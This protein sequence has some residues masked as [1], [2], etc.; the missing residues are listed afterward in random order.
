MKNKKLSEEEKEFERLIRAK[1]AN[2]LL[3]RSK[4]GVIAL[5]VGFRVKGGELTNEKVVK[6]YVAKKIEKKDLSDKDLIPSKLKINGKL[7]PTD[8]EEGEIDQIQIFNL[9]TRPLVGGC[10][11]SPHN[12]W[13]TGT[14]G[15]CITLNDDRTYILSNNHVLADSNQLA[16]GTNIIQPSRGDGGDPV[17]DVIASLHDFVRLRFG[18]FT[19]NLFGLTFTL[20]HTNIVDAAIAEVNDDFNG[21]NREIHWAGYPNYEKPPKSEFWK[22]LSYLGRRVCKMGRTTHYTV[23]K[24][25]SV[26]YDTWVGGYPGGQSAWFEDQIRIKGL[27]KRPFSAGGDSGSLVVDVET[28][29]PIGLLFSGG[30]MFTNSNPIFEVMSRLNI[31]QI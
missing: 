16:I 5:D 29:E 9:R 19:V 31:P 12:R 4:P 3:L 10:S 26:S 14:G 17:N 13:Y 22:R 30:G 21:A 28:N 20:P 23:G 6:V 24:V 15:V 18:T 7:V 1:N 2:R 11:I 25:T 27:N 8:V